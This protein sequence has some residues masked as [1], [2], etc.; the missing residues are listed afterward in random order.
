M[1]NSQKKKS[2]CSLLKKSDKKRIRKK[3]KNILSL[4]SNQ[5]NV[6]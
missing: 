1:D 5:R 4:F 2:K 6:N 3:I